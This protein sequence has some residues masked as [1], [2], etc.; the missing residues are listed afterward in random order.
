MDPVRLMDR[1]IDRYIHRRDS[2][3]TR[4]IEWKKSKKYTRAD[5]GSNSSIFHGG[6]EVQGI[7]V[8]TCGETCVEVHRL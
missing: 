7:D 6:M 2:G 1:C 3:A 5:Q 4:M 8:G